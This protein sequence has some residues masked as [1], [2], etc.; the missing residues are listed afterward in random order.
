MKGQHALGT[1]IRRAYGET[2][3]IEGRFEWLFAEGDTL[4]LC[5]CSYVFAGTFFNFSDYNTDSDSNR[6]LGRLSPAACPHTMLVL[7]Q[8]QAEAAAPVP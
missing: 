4:Y 2:E 5:V 8:P 1:E 6:Q 3:R 7:Q